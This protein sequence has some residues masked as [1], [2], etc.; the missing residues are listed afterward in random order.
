M[1]IRIVQLGTPRLRNEGLRIGTVRR[2]P[3]GVRKQ[4]HASQD[5]FD[6]WLPNLAP[7]AA[8]LRASRAESD[9]ARRRR[10][11]NARFIKEMRQPENRRLLALLAGLSH[12]GNFSVGCYCDDERSCHRGLLRQLLKQ[13]GATVIR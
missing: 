13:E 11:F 3:R 2:P 1:A 12:H 4:D 7:S 9:S 6:I 5:W 10:L 8:L